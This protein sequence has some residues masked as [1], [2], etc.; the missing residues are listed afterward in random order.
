M[1]IEDN[2]AITSDGAELLTCVPRSVEEIEALM[3]EGVKDPLPEPL[4][5]S[6]TA[7]WNLNFDQSVDLW[8]QSAGNRL[9]AMLNLQHQQQLATWF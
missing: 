7:K 9:S 5:T 2:I 1:R 4:V 3:A 6:P 8:T